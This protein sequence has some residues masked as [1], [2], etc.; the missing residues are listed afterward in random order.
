MKFSPE[1]EAA[2]RALYTRQAHQLK[3]WAAWPSLPLAVK[4]EYCLWAADVLK[5]LKIER[6]GWNEEDGSP[7]TTLA[8][9][10]WNER[11]DAILPSADA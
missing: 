9:I 5:A 3:Q 8:D 11:L 1:L 4:E 2:G 7:K 6:A 10:D